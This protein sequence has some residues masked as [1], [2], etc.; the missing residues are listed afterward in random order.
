M[1]HGGLDLQASGLLGSFTVLGDLLTQ[2]VSGLLDSGLLGS[3]IGIGGTGIGAGAG[4]WAAAGSGAGDAVRE[5]PRLQFF[6]PCLTFAIWR[7]CSPI[8]HELAMIIH[9]SQGTLNP[10]LVVIGPAF[11][12]LG[13]GRGLRARASSACTRADSLSV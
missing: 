2:N 7:E 11:G 3:G 1:L 13:C 12:C 4:C 5:R 10:A 6:G 9:E 8:G